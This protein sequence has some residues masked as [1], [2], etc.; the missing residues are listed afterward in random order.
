MGVAQPESSENTKSLPQAPFFIFACMPRVCHWLRW[1]WTTSPYSQSYGFSSS[2]EWMWELD[3]EESWAPKNGCFWTVVLEKL[4]EIQ[5]VLHKGDQSWMFIGRS[6]AEAPIIL[7]DSREK[8]LMLGKMEG[9][10]RK[11]R[12][13]MRWLDGITDSMD[14][15][16]SK[17]VKDR[18]GLAAVP[19]V[20]ESDTTQRVNHGN[21]RQQKML[22]QTLNIIKGERT[23]V[24]RIISVS[25]IINGWGNPEIWPLPA[26]L[27]TFPLGR[28]YLCPWT[29]PVPWDPGWCQPLSDPSVFVHSCL[30]TMETCFTD[31]PPPSTGVLV[32]TIHVSPGDETRKMSGKWH[33]AHITVCDYHWDKK[34]IIFPPKVESFSASLGIVDIFSDNSLLSI[35]FHDSWF[36]M[37]Y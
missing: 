3:Y 36:T 12:R 35:L 25:H 23:G 13:R 28:L 11:G 1:E 5:P 14:M 9:G 4:K 18:E 31:K 15:S 34:W 16:L 32:L 37:L 10:R 21:K 24:Q 33:K 27:Y 22:I 19:R 30:S 8:T 2:H 29:A 7:M 6:D 26:F 20:T 17:R